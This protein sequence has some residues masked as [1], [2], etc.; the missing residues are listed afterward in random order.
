MCFLQLKSKLSWRLSRFIA[1]LRQQLFVYRDL[2]L[3][4]GHPFDGPPRANL[5]EE[6]PPPLLAEL[7]GNAAD[8]QPQPNSGATSAAESTMAGAPAMGPANLDSSESDCIRG[9]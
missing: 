5:E 9:S 1:L 8:P 4:L 6:L 7:Y 2:R 3:L